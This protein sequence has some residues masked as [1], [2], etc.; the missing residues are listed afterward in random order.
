MATARG[1]RSEDAPDPI[2][3]ATPD[4][5]LADAQLAVGRPEYV[6]GEMAAAGPEDQAS[7]DD[8]SAGEEPAE[9]EPGD[10]E[11]SGAGGGGDYDEDDD[12]LGPEDSGS[13]GR[14]HSGS[15]A[16]SA[17]RERAGSRLVHFLQG[18]WRELQRVQWPD[19]RQVMQATGVVI[20]FVIVAGVYLGVADFVATKVVKLIL[21]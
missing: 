19:R 13:G 14:R 7:P 10:Q 15:A 16:V 12:D 6:E 18:S 2:E 21:P 20:G 9:A 4:V 8:D 5:E 3:H 1:N 17:P 11:P